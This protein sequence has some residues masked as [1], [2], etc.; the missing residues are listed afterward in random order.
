MASPRGFE[1]I[2]GMNTIFT[3]K[4]SFLVPHRPRRV[5]VQVHANIEQE[6]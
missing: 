3:M 4:V 1:R 6:V 5:Q 2:P